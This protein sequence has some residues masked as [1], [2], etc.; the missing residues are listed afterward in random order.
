VGA[1]PN[2]GERM[3]INSV[4]QGSA[5]DLIKIAML[6]VYHRIRR[7]N[8]PSKMLLQVH[9]ELV[10]ETPADAVEQEAS[11]V[12]QEMVDAGKQLGLIVPLKVESGWGKNWQE[13]K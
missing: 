13:V 10:F 11:M 1:L 12:R 7:E 5:A 8:R 3:A 4:V 6:N 9:D 2:A